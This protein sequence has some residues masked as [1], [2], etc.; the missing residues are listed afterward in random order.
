MSAAQ[1]RATGSRRDHRRPE[2]ERGAAWVRPLRRALQAM[3]ATFRLVH[4]TARTAAASERCAH[5]R[6]VQASRQLWDASG[7]MV[8]AS[9]RQMKAAEQLAELE[10]V[11]A[12]TPEISS[13]APSLFVAAV[14]QWV[15][16]S[17]RLTETSAEVQALHLEV[18][19]GLESGELVPEPAG[20][21]PRIAVV[22]RPVPLRA[23]LRLRLARVRDRIAPLLRRR[24]R[25]P[26]PAGLR[27]PRP[28]V[29]GRAP[30]LS[31]LCAL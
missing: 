31:S 23:F 12:R 22:P 21:R 9:F 10:A 4:S 18:L 3:D 27:V 20:R 2:G 13:L 11:I 30:P 16:L 7:R 8:R 26:R 24:R 19:D 5:R 28:S 14:A 29:L 25:T 17:A 1:K 6:P 15:D